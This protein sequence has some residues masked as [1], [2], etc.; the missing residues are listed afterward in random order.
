M[1]VSSSRG[2]FRLRDRTESALSPA[3]QAD[4]LPTEPSGKS[5]VPDLV[6]LL[7]CNIAGSLFLFKEFV[8]HEVLPV[9][10]I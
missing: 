10:Q 3:L 8:P 6:E 2:S 5:Q 7:V 1:A 4:S 9:K